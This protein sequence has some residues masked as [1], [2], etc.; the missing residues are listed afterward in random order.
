[1]LVDCQLF[2]EA[3]L[4]CRGAAVACMCVFLFRDRLVG[5][6]AGSMAY[7][8]WT[9]GLRVGSL[10]SLRIGSALVAC[11][12]ANQEGT[13]RSRCVGRRSL[14][15][16]GLARNTLDMCHQVVTVFLAG[17]CMRLAVLCPSR[18][19]LG[20]LAWMLVVVACVAATTRR[21]SC[22]RIL[23]CPYFG[24]GDRFRCGVRLRRVG[25]AVRGI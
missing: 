20:L 8:P 22:G 6:S 4:A 5:G 10:P 1:M 13:L 7:I 17:D 11:R 23:D 15:A 24:R 16:A 3:F 9:S 19:R 21:R 14:P 12:E 25:R 18:F 2:V